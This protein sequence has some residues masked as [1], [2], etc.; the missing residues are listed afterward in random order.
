[1]L[2]QNI[3]YFQVTRILLHHLYRSVH[4]DP[5]RTKQFVE[6]NQRLD[7]EHRILTKTRKYFEEL[8]FDGHSTRGEYNIGEC[9]IAICELCCETRV[10]N[11]RSCCKFPACIKCLAHHA[12]STVMEGYQTVSCPN[13][14][15]RSNFKYDE[16]IHRLTFS[17]FSNAL[18]VYLVRCANIKKKSHEYLCPN[19][20]HILPRGWLFS[21]H[22]LLLIPLIMEMLMQ[23]FE[24]R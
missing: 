8:W 24:V 2:N 21:T 13:Y 22:V 11:L 12:S 20:G 1:M 10:L 14:S 4:S 9:R 3:S 5:A 17:E 18:K 16:I 7:P 23:L 15:C 6:E 19:C